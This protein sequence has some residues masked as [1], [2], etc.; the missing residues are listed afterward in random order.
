MA[1]GGSFWRLGPRSDGWGPRSA[2]FWERSNRCQRGTP[3]SARFCV[4]T[5]PEPGG[6]VR[7]IAQK[8]PISKSTRVIVRRNGRL[9]RPPVDFWLGSTTTHESQVTN[10]LP[11]RIFTTR[12]VAALATAARTS[13]LTPTQDFPC[14]EGCLGA[15]DCG[16]HVVARTH[17]ELPVHG[18]ALQYRRLPCSQAAPELGLGHPPTALPSPRL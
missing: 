9:R 8:R 6:I 2:R 3:D 7:R 13:L 12:G 5:R 18:A 15:G 17:V 11:A 10:E 1:G 14:G 16:S 4:G